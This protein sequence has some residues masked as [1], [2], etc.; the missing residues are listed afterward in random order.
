MTT[1]TLYRISYLN[2][3]EVYELYA[4]DVS[5]QELMGFIT[6][7]ELQFDQREGVVIDP[8]EERLKTEFSGVKKLHVPIQSV[9]KIEEVTAKKSCK[10]K[11]LNPKANVPDR[12]PHTGPTT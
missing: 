6:V 8:T 7:S 12:Q 11:T 4:R 5:S 10:I 9:L 1:K 3:Q 2:H